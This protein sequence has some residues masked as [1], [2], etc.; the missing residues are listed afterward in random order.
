MVKE[1]PGAEATKAFAGHL[2]SL[3]PEGQVALLD[4]L[5]ARKDAAAR[6]AVLQAAKS[7]KPAVAAA[8]LRA[9]GA[10]GSAA[11]VA[12]LAKVAATDAAEAGKAAR[13]SLARLRGD[14]VNK[15]VITAIDAA[16]AKTKVELINALAARVATEAAPVVEKCA[17]DADAGVRKAA[18]EAI[19]ALGDEK[20]VNTLVAMLKATKDAGD[21]ASIETALTNICG[22]VREKAVADLVAG[23]QGSEADA[24]VVLLNALGRAGGAK[25]LETLLA[26]TK[27]TDEKVL[28]GAIRVLSNWPEQVAVAPLLALA[29]GG[30]AKENHQVLALRGVVRLARVRETPMKDRLAALNEAMKLAKKAPEKKLVLGALGETENIEALKLVAPFV[31]DPTLTEEAGSAA[32]RI[33]DKAGGRD[34]NLARST[35]EEVIKSVKNA[36]TKKDA[37]KALQK[38][39]PAPKP[40]PERSPA[41]SGQSPVRS[42]GRRASAS[43]PPAFLRRRPRA[44]GATAASSRPCR[45][46]LGCPRSASLR[47]AGWRG[48]MVQRAPLGHYDVLPPA[49]GRPRADRARLPID[50]ADGLDERRGGL[51]RPADDLDL[52]VGLHFAARVADRVGPDLHLVA[53]AE[54]EHQVVAVEFVPGDE[55]ARRIRPVDQ[56]PG[57]GQERHVRPPQVY[58]AAVPAEAVVDDR[59]VPAVLD[60]HPAALQ[61]VA[62]LAVALEDVAGDQRVLRVA[63]PQPADGVAHHPVADH[64]VA[65]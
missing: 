7:D 55:V 58:R 29:G 3:P 56:S 18:I 65:E 10:V 4:A 27:S 26:D 20:Q 23:I 19:G 16:D 46:N 48:G 1:M 53:S 24:H 12:M 39:G 38:L 54:V 34:K 6:D 9:L 14:D 42:G 43:R 51:L 59:V 61:P 57:L 37:E 15:T 36:R 40:K 22:R 49:E 52:R 63:A 13:E 50:R 8:A 33:A 25:A 17:K 45:S 2:A 47:R 21:V 41:R 31:S 44:P 30:A 64:P 62:H 60:V 35:L 28:D 5:E 32:V 11:D